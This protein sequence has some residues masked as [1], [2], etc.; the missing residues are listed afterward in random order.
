MSDCGHESQVVRLFALNR[1]TP[2]AYAAAMAA[3]KTQEVTSAR[4]PGATRRASGTGPGEA[5]EG[6]KEHV[7]NGSNAFSVPVGCIAVPCRY[8]LLL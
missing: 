1:V 3:F 4:G 5:D 6:S 2:Q 7:L 8:V